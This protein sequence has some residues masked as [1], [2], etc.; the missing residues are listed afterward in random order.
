MCAVVRYHGRFRLCVFLL[1][2]PDFLFCHVESDYDRYYQITAI[3][4]YSR[5]RIAELIDKILHTD[6]LDHAGIDEFEHI[7]KGLRDLMKYIP[8]GKIIY[9]TDFDDEI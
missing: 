3:D 5:K 9:D 2:A 4:L 8:V 6:Y 7:R 1:Y